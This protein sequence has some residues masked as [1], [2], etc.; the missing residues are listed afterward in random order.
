MSFFRKISFL[1][2]SLLIFQIGFALALPKLWGTYSLGNHGLGIP[3][4]SGESET[5]ESQLTVKVS[6]KLALCHHLDRGHIILEVTGGLP[7]YS[8]TWNNLEKVQNRYNLYAGTYTVFIKDSNGKEHEERIIIQPPFPLIVEMG[9]IQQASCSNNSDGSAKINIKFGRGEPYKIEW[10]HGLTDELEAENLAPG[11][12]TVRVIDMYN[13]DATLSFEIKSGAD[14]FEIKENVTQINCSDNAKGAI[15][16]V[17]SGGNA[18]YSFLWSNGSTSKDIENLEAGIYEV[19][20][21]DTA[22]CTVTKSFEIKSPSSMELSVGRVRHN[23]CFGSNEGEIDVEVKGGQEPYTF[24]WNNG[25][26]SKNLKDL[27]SGTYT[28]KVKDANGCEISTVVEIEQP[29]KL[30]AKIE[31][32]IDVNCENGEAKGYAWVRIE[33]GKSPYTINWSNGVTDKQEIEFNQPGEFEVEVVDSFGCRT[34]E[35]IRI[36]FPFDNSIA[37]RIDFKVRK[38]SI[39]SESEVQVLEPLVFESEIAEDFIAWEWDFGDGAAASERD[40]VHVFKNPGEFDVVLRAYDIY[41]C[42][43][44]QRKSVRVLE[45]DEWITI[46]NA[47]TPNGDGL[48]DFFMPVLKGVVSFEMN[49]FNHWGEPLY[50]HQGLEGNGWDGTYMGKLLPT[51]NYVY[52]ISLSTISGDSIQKTGTLTIVR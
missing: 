28:L 52:K 40:P 38:L 10:S 1:L 27:P 11:T 44:V 21:T 49:I 26:S 7:P 33:G 19:T 3:S 32:S 36:E 22:G 42:S 31:S 5:E 24:L 39:S 6:G 46:P 35:K 25:A 47:F 41:G 2:I 18:P 51:G 13:C 43:S 50:T 8:F 17:L 48:N 30:S 15:S 23:Q 45:K 14:S 16:L 29:I 34:T 37:G 4:F 20:I 12:Y 9:A